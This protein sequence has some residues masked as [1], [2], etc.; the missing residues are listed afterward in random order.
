MVRT[1]QL[2]SEGGG[3]LKPKAG[4]DDCFLPG[5]WM[6]TGDIGAWQLERVNPLTGAVVHSSAAL[7]V[8]AASIPRKSEEDT[9]EFA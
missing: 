4:D 8:P 7:H 1:K 5:G 2:T 9:D 6:A 3:Y